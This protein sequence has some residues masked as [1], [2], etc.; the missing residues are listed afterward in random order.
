[1]YPLATSFPE[2]STTVV[3]HESTPATGSSADQ[4][5]VID[6]A[7]PPSP[8][9]KR[10]RLT[11]VQTP[12]AATPDT[13]AI[14]PEQLNEEEHSARPNLSIV[15]TAM[16]P[17]AA[18][19]EQQQQ[20]TP[21]TSTTSPTPSSATTKHCRST[22]IRLD[23]SCQV[24]PDIIKIS[25]DMTLTAFRDRI[26]QYQLTHGQ[27]RDKPIAAMI[28]RPAGF[29]IV[30]DDDLGQSGWEELQGLMLESTEVS[31]EVEWDEQIVSEV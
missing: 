30:W 17:I 3:K 28:V 6:D 31:M 25:S 12:R 23:W 15:T 8:A 4:P 10:R 26:Q 7:E 9:P 19:I 21:Q 11:V 20:P 24:A 13:A 27:L 16:P 2:I 5:F 18:H 1:M 29:R 14:K 22:S